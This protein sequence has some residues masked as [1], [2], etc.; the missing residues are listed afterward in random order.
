MIVTMGPEAGSASPEIVTQR[1][2]TPEGIV[3]HRA[4]SDQGELIKPI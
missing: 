4:C 2:L 3:T 1:G